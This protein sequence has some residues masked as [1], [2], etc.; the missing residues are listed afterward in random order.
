[1]TVIHIFVTNST[2]MRQLLR[3]SIY[4]DLGRKISNDKGPHARR[5]LEVAPLCDS[6]TEFKLELNSLLNN[7]IISVQ[8]EI[9]TQFVVTVEFIGLVTDIKQRN[10]CNQVD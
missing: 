6:Q 7:L 1:M 10:N 8:P 2:Y 9:R 4:Q 5:G 3:R